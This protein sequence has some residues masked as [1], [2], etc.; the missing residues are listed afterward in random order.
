VRGDNYRE[1]MYPKQRVLKLSTGRH[2]A[3]TYFPLETMIIDL[4]AKST[5]MD[6]QNLLFSDFSDPTKDT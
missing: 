5:L 3:L 6:K 4:L 2:V 1:Y